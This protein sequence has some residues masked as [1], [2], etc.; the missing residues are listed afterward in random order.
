MQVCGGAQGPGGSGWGAR[1][2]GPG[3]GG[4]ALCFAIPDLCHFQRFI[5]FLYISQ[6]AAEVQEKYIGVQDVLSFRLP[7]GMRFGG[8]VI[9]G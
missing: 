8:V 1:G 4:L 7:I 3:G 2:P 5:I 6:R 9:A